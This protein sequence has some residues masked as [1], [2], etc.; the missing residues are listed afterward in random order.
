[1]IKTLMLPCIGLKR[2]VINIFKKIDQDSDK[3]PQ[4]HYVLKIKKF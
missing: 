1:M 4:N 3:L 2:T